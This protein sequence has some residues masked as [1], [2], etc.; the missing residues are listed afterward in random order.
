MVVVL[1]RESKGLTAGTVWR[2]ACCLRWTHHTQLLLRPTGHT[3]PHSQLIP[4]AAAAAAATAD[5]QQQQNNTT[6]ACKHES[7]PHDQTHEDSRA[8]RSSKGPPLTTTTCSPCVSVCKSRVLLLVA[9]PLLQGLSCPSIHPSQLPHS[10]HPI[11][12]V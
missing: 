12:P 2:V 7:L 1:C 11:H 4:A 8:M 10:S 9:L 6:H 5:P 3:N